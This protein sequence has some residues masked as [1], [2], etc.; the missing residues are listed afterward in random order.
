MSVAIQGENAAGRDIDAI[1]AQMDERGYCTIEGVITTEEAD[2]ARAILE[3]FLEAERNEDAERNRS[4]RVGRIAVKHPLFL[5]LMCHPLVLAVWRRYLG[6][7]VICSTWTANTILPGH[8]RHHWHSD[9]PYHRLEPPWPAG[10]FTGQTIW[11]LD[12]FTVENGA[13]A[14]APYSHRRLHPPPDKDEWRAD[15]EIVTGTRGSVVVAH[16]AYWHTARP[17]TTGRQR[18]CLL[19]MYIRPCFTTQEDMRGQLAEIEDPSETVRQLMGAYQYQPRNI[20][21]Y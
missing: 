13:T 17:N 12:D 21:P 8:V 11:M 7:D 3:K 15:G 18:S 16:G 1:I 20:L 5:E 10:N 6:E 14:I 2:R 4:Q 19:G 9:F